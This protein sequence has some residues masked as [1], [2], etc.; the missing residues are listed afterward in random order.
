MGDLD[1]ERAGVDELVVVEAGEG[2]AGDVADDVAAGALGGEAD[3]GEGVDDLDEGADG[4]PVELDV[5]AGGDVGEVAGVL[6]GDAR[7]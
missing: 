6:L 7:R 5:L 3:L 2:A 1:G 4:E